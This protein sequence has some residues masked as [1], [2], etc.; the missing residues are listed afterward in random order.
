MS[1]G[2]NFLNASRKGDLYVA[3]SYTSDVFQQWINRAGIK[4]MKFGNIK[5][6]V[7][8]LAV[9]TDAHR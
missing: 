2:T 4:I 9:D 7:I 1:S 5:N 3:F 8:H 6:V